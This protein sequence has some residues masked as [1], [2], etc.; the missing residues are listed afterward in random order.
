MSKKDQVN[1][2]IIG[3]GFIAETRAR[4]Y[5]AVSGHG[6]R[7]A[8]VASRSRDHAMNYARAHQISHV[9]DHYS[10]ILARPDIDVL[11]LC[12]P[13]HLHRPM[14]EAAA[15]A[16]KH[17][18]C[19]KPLTAFDREAVPPETDFRTVPRGEMLRVALAN[20]DAMV[21]AVERAQVHLMYAENWVY[22]PPIVKANRLASASGGVILEMRG[23]E[24]HSG[25]HSPYAKEWK[26]AGG[27][28]LIRLG[29]HPIGA[30][31]HLKRQEGLRRSGRPIRAR[32]VVAEVADLTRNPAFEKEEQHW[33]GTG[34]VDVENW[35]S[36]I[37]TFE[38]GTRG[39]A[40]ASD[41]MLG[42]M[43][44]SLQIALS[45]AHIKCNMEHSGLV[46]A[47][48]PSP[49]VFERE[50]L[51]EKLETKAGWS[52]PAPD[53]DWMQ[54]HIHMVQD[55]VESVATGRSPLADGRLG[56]DA[57]EVVYAGYVSAAEGRRVELCR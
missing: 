20:A 36:L 55:F 39:I 22:A 3:A 32:A 7:L 5:A 10:D 11:D 35:A 56:R 40:W 52:S 28:A 12:V 24:C 18:I 8:A 46:S 37:I 25:S 48:A 57:I 23:G 44:S 1:V 6:V 54:G 42:G 49:A 14:T 53:E 26:Y 17:V 33:V 34:W 30:M 47:F 19:P 51:M 38:D 9:Y 21:A 41:A 50:Y 13:N 45:N 4:C 43:E 15:A 16:G 31:L 27:G 2:A 29:V